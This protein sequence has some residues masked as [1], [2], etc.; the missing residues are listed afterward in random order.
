M[1]LF[2]LFISINMN[3]GVSDFQYITKCNLFIIEGDGYDDI[4]GAHIFINNNIIRVT[5]SS[6]TIKFE[7]N[8]NDFEVEST[9][10]GNNECIVYIYNDMYDIS[11][12]FF[13]NERYNTFKE[14][15]GI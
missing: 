5:N 12:Y 14:T 9:C 13:S 4:V 2:N 10:T 7:F 11:F 1:T 15:I 8:I 3:F 6:Q